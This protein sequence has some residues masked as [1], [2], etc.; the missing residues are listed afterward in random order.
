MVM[1]N[2]AAVLKGRETFDEPERL[3]DVGTRRGAPARWPP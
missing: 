2:E 3:G 1:H